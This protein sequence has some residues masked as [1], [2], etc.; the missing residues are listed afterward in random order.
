MKG[1]SNV[2]LTLYFSKSAEISALRSSK[3]G[4]IVINPRSMPSWR[5][6]A[7]IGTS[8][9]A[10][11]PA[12]QMMISRSVPSRSSRT[13]PDSRLFASCMFTIFIASV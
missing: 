9:A 13:N 2:F 6:G 12:T 1:D 7:V 10:A 3:S 11:L 5:G 8:F 4:A